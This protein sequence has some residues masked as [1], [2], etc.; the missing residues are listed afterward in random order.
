MELADDGCDVVMYGALAK[1][2]DEL[3]KGCIVDGKLQPHLVDDVSES[4]LKQ[5]QG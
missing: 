2:V 4:L 1:Y 3:V 5:Y